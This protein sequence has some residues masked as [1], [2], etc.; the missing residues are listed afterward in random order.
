MNIV[1]LK[2]VLMPE[3]FRMSEFF[4][5]QLKGKYAF[6]IQMRYIFPLDSLC[7]QKYIK[8]E[9]MEP[10]DFLKDTILPHIDLYS[11]EYC[12]I[13][14]VNTFIDLCETEEINNIY[15]FKASNEYVTD[16]DIDV[17][18]IRV[19][20]TWLASE[21]L[22]L[23][24]GIYDEHLGK[25]TT[26][27]IH[28]LEFYKNNMYNDVVKY[29]DIFGGSSIGFSKSGVLG[30]NSCGCINNTSMLSLGNVSVCDAKQIYLKNVHSLMVQTF[31]D[32]AFWMSVNKDFIKIFKKYIDN[33]I[34]V[35]FTVNIP[36]QPDRFIECS[37]NNESNSLNNG[38]LSNL[39]IALG[40]IINNDTTGHINFIHDSLYNWAEY[41]YDYMIWE[42]K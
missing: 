23:N 30:S 35:G 14:F 21:L 13:D 8:Y 2:D 42:I 6:W 26:E 3:E 4:N 24:T 17:S 19:F 7:Y 40:Y 15:N 32:P 37:C 20:R 10:E 33:I 16:S 29:L 28:M 9:Q 39:S 41:L 1:K 34:K 36:K 25:Y 27:V 5:T 11:E 18:K 31:E 12:M 22:K 38:I